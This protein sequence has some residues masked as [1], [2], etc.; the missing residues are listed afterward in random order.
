[1]GV[2]IIIYI[3]FEGSF[4]FRYLCVCEFVCMYF[5]VYVWETKLIKK[6]KRR[7]KRDICVCYIY[8]NFFLKF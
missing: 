2:V 3:F 7:G 1:M 6:E 5:N 8:I 4:L